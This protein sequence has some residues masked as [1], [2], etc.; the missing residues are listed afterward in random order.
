MGTIIRSPRADRRFRSLQT[1]DRWKL[2][3]TN[4]KPLVLSV[5][6][7]ICLQR[8]W[9]ELV[10]KTL[11]FSFRYLL[12]Q[13]NYLRPAESKTMSL[14]LKY[15][16]TNFR[17]FSILFNVVFILLASLKFM[18]QIR[19]TSVQRAVIIYIE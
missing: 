9:K 7:N 11:Q 17:Y 6:C 1:I 19:C 5:L 15:V 18:L 16:P 4:L 8:F 10:S 2:A 14:R 12:E 3:S 13:V